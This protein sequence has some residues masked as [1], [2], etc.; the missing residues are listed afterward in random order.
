MVFPSTAVTLN[1]TG[2]AETRWSERVTANRRRR[3]RTFYGREDY[4]AS[5]TFLVGSNL[6]SKYES[7]RG[8]ERFLML[9]MVSSTAQVPIEAGIHTYNFTC[10]IPTECPSSF[11]GTNG[12]VRYMTNVTLVRPWKFDQSYTRCF[13][14]LKVM[15][16]NFDS[17][18][19]RVCL[20]R[21]FTE[22]YLSMIYICFIGSRPQ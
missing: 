2:Y 10:Q 22:I 7:S 14:V 19:L 3:R 9:L 11:E 21:Q 5:K 8:K 17:P 16:L 18:L 15:D 13:T 4:I 1:I 20:A 6:S 12:R